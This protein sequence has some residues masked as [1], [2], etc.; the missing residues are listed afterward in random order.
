MYVNFKMTSVE[1]IPGIG[2]GGTKKSDGGV[3]SSM[4]YLL[5]C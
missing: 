5:D 1:T 4:I 2:R 3:N